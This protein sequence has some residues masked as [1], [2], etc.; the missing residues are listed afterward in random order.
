MMRTNFLVYGNRYVIAPR[1]LKTVSFEEAD[2]MK[3]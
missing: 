2:M 3:L 1:K